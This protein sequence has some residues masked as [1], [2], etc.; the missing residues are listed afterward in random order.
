MSTHLPQPL[1]LFDGVCNLCNVAV[2]F[3]IE[4]DPNAHVRFAS[5]QSETGQAILNQLGRPLEQFDSFVLWE[6]GRFHEKSTAALRVARHLS[7]GWPLLYGFMIVPK[8]I[9]DAVYSLVA[10]HRYRW[11][12]KRDACMLPTPALK[13]RFLA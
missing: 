1:L 7:G 8:G 13:M 4:R 11:F 12:G 5:L 10:R 3:V 9:R 2:T 6:D